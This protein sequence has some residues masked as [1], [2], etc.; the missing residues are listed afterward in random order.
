M[1]IFSV[2]KTWGGLFALTSALTWAVA[3]IIYRKLGDRVSPWGINLGK[4]AIAVVFFGLLVALS[5]KSPVDNRTFLFLGIS[6]LLSITFGD[7]FFLMSL[8]RLGPRLALMLTTLIPVA[9]ILLAVLF[10]HERLCFVNWLGIFFTLAGVIWVV[11]EQV[12][13]NHR[14]PAWR[15]GIKYGILTIICC[16]V[17]VIFSKVVIASTS[18]LRAA[19]IRQVWGLGGLAVVGLNG[20]KMKKWLKPLA[21]PLLLKKLFLAAFTGTFLGTWFCLLALK[22]ID[23]S[24]ATTLNATS[25]LFIL[26]LSFF[27]LK[28]KISS[29]AVIGSIIAVAGVGMIFSGLR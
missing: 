22:Y 24:I 3:A 7:T 26:P 5:D 10:L 20:F 25:P 2:D 15:A 13:G 1:D 29:R 28:E 19:L 18:A 11:W 14:L 4:G 27:F 8:V 21:Q 6:G 17:G 16:A 9:T 23:A 12:P